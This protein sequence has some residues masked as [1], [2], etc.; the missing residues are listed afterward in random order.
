MNR[1]ELNVVLANNGHAA[2][3]R[4]NSTSS[5][6]S[7]IPVPRFGSCSSK[8]QERIN[9]LRPASAQQHQTDTG[10]EKPP[11]VAAQ[12]AA[13]ERLDSRASQGNLARASVGREL[14]SSPQ[15]HQV[16]DCRGS[17]HDLSGSPQEARWRCKFEEAEKR[18]KALLHKSEAGKFLRDSV[19]LFPLGGL[20]RLDF[21]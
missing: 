6:G 2:N 9:S 10:S 3:V 15:L 19:L 13:F 12:R 20:T 7:Q 21:P 1:S 4:G 14:G 11:S 17:R 18:R 16:S 5:G 8:L